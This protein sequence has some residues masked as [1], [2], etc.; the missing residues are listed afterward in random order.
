MQINKFHIFFFIFLLFSSFQ[1]FSQTGTVKGT[2]L[3]AD[4]KEPLIGASILLEGTS[5]GSSADVEGKYVISKV[6]AG[7]YTAV[8]TSVGYTTQKI[9]NITIES[10]KITLINSN[11]DANVNSLNEVVIVG[12]RTTS[13]E[14][15]VISEIKEAQQVVSGISQEQIIKS[16]DR[17][18]GEVVR[19]IPGVTIIDNKFINIRGLNDRYN[20]VW[21]NDAVAPSSE[22]DRKAFSFDIIPS[23]LLDRVLIFKTPSPELPGDF[24]GGMV[25]VY[26]RK[27]SY[28]EKSLSV[29]ISGGYRDGTTFN[30]FTSDQKGNLDWLG[31]GNHDRKLPDNIKVDQASAVVD[32]ISAKQ[33]KNNYGL[34]KKSAIP[35][36]RFNISYLTG[37]KIGDRSVGSLTALTYANT[38]T[39]FDISRLFSFNGQDNLLKDV[40]STN[41]VRI[42]ALQ[43][44]IFS[45]GDAGKLEFRNMFNQIS[46]NQVTE[47]KILNTDGKDQNDFSYQMGY[48]SRST[49]NGQLAGNH[50]LKIFSR[51]TDFEWV[52]GYARSVKNEPDLRRTGYSYPDSLYQGLAQGV[53]LVNGSRLYQ[54]LKENI[55]S[56]N[57]GIKHTITE[58]ASINL[59]T[60]I[61]LKDRNFY[62]RQFGYYLNNNVRPRPQL[63]DQLSKLPIGQIF[64]PNNIGTQSNNGFTMAEDGDGILQPTS[65]EVV[66]KLAYKGKNYLY[67]GYISGNF[68]IGSKFKL[69]TGIRYEHN[70]QGLIAGSKDGPVNQKIVTDKFLPSANLSYNINDKNLIRFAYGRTLNRPEFREVSPYSFYD[71]DLNTLIYGNPNLKVADIDNFDLRYEVYPSDGE[72]FHVGVFYKNFTNPI[73]ASVVSTSNVAFTYNNAPKAYAAGLEIDVRKKLNTLP[74]TFFNHYTLVFNGSLI[75]SAVAVDGNESWTANR[76]LQGQSPYTINTGLYF[77]DQKTGWQVS[78]L[79]NVFGPRIIIVGRANPNPYSE[80]VEMPRHTVDLT[81]TKSLFKEK[82]SLSL[83]VSDLLNQRVLMLQ[84]N[85]IKKDNKFDRNSDPAWRDYRRG[86]YF[87]FTIKYNIF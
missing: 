47:R 71:F 84:D 31:F 4:T 3:D 36:Q 52:L 44:F 18:A 33:F 77:N 48:Q 51:K 2:L 42:G 69:L 8:I 50:D 80:I 30:N 66:P 72:L 64:D 39:V 41:N 43:N 38:F 81:V 73:E 32:P 6:P 7:V 11:V 35:D 56:A 14:V 22:T 20:T 13:T 28:N 63:F 61:E 58:N 75:K 74:N 67:A 10:D 55:Y 86:S 85:P 19:R 45:L 16:Q 5:F 82:L 68:N 12:S 62:A 65:G 60:Y 76:S 37:F 87:N 54:N 83:G 24:A 46:S 70:E 26:T 79:Y 40:Q 49:Y 78:A 1:I 34:T 17:D 29:S 15:A 21:L 59:G 25:K 27:P 23:N 53:D 57:I 9:P